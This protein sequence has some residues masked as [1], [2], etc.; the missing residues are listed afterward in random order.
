MNVTVLDYG[1]GN[2]HSLKKAVEAG[3]A[4]VTVTGSLRQALRG[5]AM[6][7]P[8]VGSFSAAVRVLAEGNAVVRTALEEGMPCLGICLGMQLLFEGSEEGEGKG[9]GVLPGGVRR[10]RGPKVPQMGWNDVNLG[11][12]PLFEGVR[13]LVA[14]YANSYVCHPT[15]PGMI[16]ATSEYGGNVFPAAVRHGHCWG[17]QF[18][19][20]KSSDPGLRIIRN[21]L[22][23]AASL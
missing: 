9:I 6:I 13:S 20:E 17:I 10:L 19:P 8:G 22:Q 21:F 23:E 12:D 3:G 4:G 1:T 15:D 11:S 16:L 14:Y 18:H 2:L 7:L 5:D